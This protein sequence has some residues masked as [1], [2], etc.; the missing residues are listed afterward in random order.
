MKIYFK[1]HVSL[2][3]DDL[4]Y[5]FS[6]RLQSLNIHFEYKHILEAVTK[7]NVIET[8]V[9]RRNVEKIYVLD[10]NVLLQDPY[11]IYSFQ[12]NEVVIPAVVLEEL[13][14][15]KRN[16]DEIG[17]NAR[18]FSKCIDK[19]RDVGK[20]HDG[21]ELE[22]GGVLRVELNHRSFLRL[23]D[24]FAEMTND[25]RII[26]VAL[27]LM[28]EEREKEDGKDVILISKD[29]LVRVKADA[30]GLKAEDFLSDRVIE[31]EHVYPGFVE[32][33]VDSS[34][35]KSFFLKGEITISELT[36]HPFY[37]HQFIIMK[38]AL[39][40]SSSALGKVEPDGKK[41]KPFLNER[42]S[43]GNSFTKCAATY[44]V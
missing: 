17:R 36:K 2:N 28:M 29:A 14:S 42:T 9:R 18:K 26:A 44:G 25:N 24:S 13:D 19:L 30:L 34:V 11:S 16:M 8:V 31:F 41:V 32:V 4:V 33:Y 1:I 5:N 35:M 7:I 15:K 20:L 21:V 37:P 22:S 12:D 38:D 23:K 6:S 43:L 3:F 27:N 39:G 10:T 40:S